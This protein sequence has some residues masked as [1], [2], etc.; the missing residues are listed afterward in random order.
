MSLV[1]R[2][3]CVVDHCQ[4]EVDNFC[5]ITPL[6]SG[7]DRVWRRKIIQENR[8]YA[9]TSSCPHFMEGKMA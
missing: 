3:I 8:V 7:P 4:V 1:Y 6:G 2:R 9:G 5:I